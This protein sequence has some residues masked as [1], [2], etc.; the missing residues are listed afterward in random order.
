MRKSMLL[1]LTIS[2]TLLVAC[3][4]EETPATTATVPPAPTA[5]DREAD[6]LP[7]PEATETVMAESTGTA[8]VAAT[9][10]ETAASTPPPLLPRVGQAPPPAPASQP[11]EPPSNRIMVADAYEVLRAGNAVIV[12]VR[13]ED[14]WQYQRIPGAINI[15][16][17]QVSARANE[18]PQD[19]WVIT[20]C[21]CPAE[22]TSGAAATTL[23]NMG[24]ERTAALVGGIQAWRGA[25]LPI[26]FGQ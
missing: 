26:E 6:V 14:A 8:P 13:N 12:D 21:S 16:L 5:V 10:V 4:K 23:Q 3:A 9:P 24:F 11:F 1:I 18:L 22:E 25:K 7:P 20:Y 17:N 2:L 19:K 15:P